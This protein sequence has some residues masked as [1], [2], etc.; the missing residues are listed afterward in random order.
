MSAQTT[1]IQTTGVEELNLTASIIMAYVSKNSVS[2]DQLPD[3][4]S[5]VHRRLKT[6]ADKEPE[7]SGALVPAVPIRKSVTPRYIISLEDGR[8]FKSLKR[9]LMAEYGM[10]PED[11]RAKWGLPADYPMIS[12]A[13]SAERSAIAKSARFGRK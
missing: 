10:T 2:S 13:Y 1:G 5:Q 7:P 8:K 11:Y 3:L 12:P 9:H 4:I 6:L